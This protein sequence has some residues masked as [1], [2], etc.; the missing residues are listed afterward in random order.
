MGERRRGGGERRSGGGRRLVGPTWGKMVTES[1][2]AA[3]WPLAD[4]AGPATAAIDPTMGERRRATA[5]WPLADLAGPATAAID[6]TMGE[7]R[8][9]GGERRSGGG[10]R[11][12]GTHMG[13]MVISPVG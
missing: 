12:V 7:R 13:K 9:G 3:S 5:S 4:L 8:R 10:R 11:L 2:A 6:P 1:R